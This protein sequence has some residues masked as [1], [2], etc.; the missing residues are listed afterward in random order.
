MRRDNAVVNNGTMGRSHPGRK[1]PEVSEQTPRVSVVIPSYDR[2]GMLAAAVRSVERQTHPSIEVIVV[3][4][5]SPTPITEEHLGEPASSLDVQIVRH[6]DNRGANAARITGIQRSTGAFVAFLDDDDR[7]HPDKLTR[8]VN[9]ANRT[10]NVAVVTSGQRYHPDDDT[11]AGTAI[12]S[13]EGEP[14]AAILQGSTLGPF[15]T[16]LVD[17]AAIAAAGVPDRSL[18]SYQDWE[19]TVRLSQVGEVAVVAEPLVTRRVGGDD[20]L[21]SAYKAKRDVTYPRFLNRHRA[22]A[23][24]YGPAVERR[25]R[26]ALAASVASAALAAG[27]YAD[28]RRFALR[29]IR[30]DPGAHRG[31]L[32]LAAG[33]GGPYSYRVAVWLRGWLRRTRRYTVSRRRS[34]TPE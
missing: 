34:P 6:A 14:T 27:E 31:Y 8:Q 3:D 15:S 22:L 1:R 24:S 25:F 11:P 4:D 16:L 17:R 26:G 19:W 9:A 32:Y 5:G 2:P 18:P 13:V 21:G 23:A 10:A 28:A 20:H 30:L 29:A 33:I 12:P 7:W